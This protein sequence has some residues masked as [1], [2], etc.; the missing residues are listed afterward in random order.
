M[1]II[2]QNDEHVEAS[3]KICRKSIAALPTGSDNLANLQEELAH[4]QWKK[5]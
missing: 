3:I 4:L 1:Y 5:F 2:T